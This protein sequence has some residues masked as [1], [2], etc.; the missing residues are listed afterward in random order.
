MSK[1]CVFSLFVEVKG[2]GDTGSQ[3]GSRIL[4]FC[5][6]KAEESRSWNGAWQANSDRDEI[7]KAASWSP[8]LIVGGHIFRSLFDKIGS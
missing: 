8:G 5:C 6:R 3:E 7:S 1:M 2:K 4:R